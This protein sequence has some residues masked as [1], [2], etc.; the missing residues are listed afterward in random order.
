[1]NLPLHFPGS[2]FES[3][4]Q[5][6]LIIFFSRVI[7]GLPF[8]VLLNLTLTLLLLQLPFYLTHFRHCRQTWGN[9]TAEIY[10]LDQTTERF[11]YQYSYLK[12]VNSI[13]EMKSLIFLHLFPI[14]NFSGQGQ[15]SKY[16][17]IKQSLLYPLRW[18]NAIGRQSFHHTLTRISLRLIN[19]GPNLVP[20]PSIGV[21][22]Q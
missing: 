5:T 22:K 21:C 17:K 9:T 7:F 20:T 4:L 2:E 10:F 1:M 13:S 8:N 18:H 3:V 14:Q 15:L 19:V 16:P 12:R 6:L 11:Q